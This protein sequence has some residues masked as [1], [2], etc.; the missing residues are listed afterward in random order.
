[1]WI[2]PLCLHDCL[3]WL[4]QDL[5]LATS[6]QNKFIESSPIPR[7]GGGI[8]E[9]FISRSIS[10]KWKKKWLLSN[11]LELF[12]MCLYRQGSANDCDIFILHL[13]W[14]RRPK[15]KTQNL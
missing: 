2:S 7:F 5:S 15:K 1:M 8:V 10:Q 14:L 9:L 4:A 11:V 12:M 6:K 3:K 13:T